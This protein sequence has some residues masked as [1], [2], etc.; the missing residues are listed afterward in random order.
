MHLYARL[1]D[2]MTNA[3][4]AWF[5]HQSPDVAHIPISEVRE[6]FKTGFASQDQSPLESK[7]TALSSMVVQLPNSR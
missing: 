5:L 6:A 3:K 1:V 2:S 7:L 4:T